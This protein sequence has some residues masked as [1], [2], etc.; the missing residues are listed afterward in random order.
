[1]F[2]AGAGASFAAVFVF[3]AAYAIRGLQ[4]QGVRGLGNRCACSIRALSAAQTMAAPISSLPRW[5]NAKWAKTSRSS[6]FRPGLSNRSRYDHVGT[7]RHFMTNRAKRVVFDG[8]VLL[9]HQWQPVR[10]TPSMVS[11]PETGTLTGRVGVT[12]R[13]I[14]VLQADSCELRDSDRAWCFAVGSGANSGSR[15]K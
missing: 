12:G 14:G 5:R 9:G 8:E 1:M 6:L 13:A 4:C 7:A 3:A 10:T 15:S 11:D 2:V